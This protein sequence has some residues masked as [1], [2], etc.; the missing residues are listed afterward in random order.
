M[1]TTT[2]YWLGAFTLAI[3]AIGLMR[4]IYTNGAPPS[5]IEVLQNLGAPPNSIMSGRELSGDP[6]Y[7]KSNDVPLANVNSFDK[8][9]TRT[10]PRDQ[11]KLVPKNPSA[12]DSAAVIGRAFPISKA[13]LDDCKMKRDYICNDVQEKLSEMSLEP[14]DSRWASE[15]EALIEHDILFE[16][17]PGRFTIR[18]IECRTSL[19]AAQVESTFSSNG[20]YGSYMGG[21]QVHHDDLNAALHTN[22]NTF[23]TETD[24]TGRRVTV[25]VITFT[26]R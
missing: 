8:F 14:R 17:L 26:R 1:R 6:R 24:L 19:C 2:F 9:A 13:I 18:D 5:K 22:F 11:A 20:I 23:A 25:T 3:V 4:Y 21:M 16:E 7:G 12:S 10:E 15:M